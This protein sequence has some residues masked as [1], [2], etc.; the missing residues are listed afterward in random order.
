MGRLRQIVDFDD[1][2]HFRKLKIFLWGGK[3]ALKVLAGITTAAT[4][5]LDI[6]GKED[7]PV[8]IYWT[9]AVIG[10]CIAWVFHSYKSANGRLA[11]PYMAACMAG[12]DGTVFYYFKKRSGLVDNTVV[13]VRSVD[14]G[15]TKPYTLAY[16]EDQDTLKTDEM[17]L[18]PFAVYDCGHYRKGQPRLIPKKK[19]SQYVV[20]I[21]A[22]KYKIFDDA[23]SM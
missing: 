7:F 1:V 3:S 16:V 5:L 19:L 9:T 10:F 2:L 8:W 23:M 13:E 20:R 6:T 12:E 22:L 4:F 11:N 18:R 15:R 14:N 17:I 21:E